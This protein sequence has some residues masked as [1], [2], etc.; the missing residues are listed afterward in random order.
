MKKLIEIKKRGSD[1]SGFT[2]LEYC[3]GAAVVV[4][5][6]WVALNALGDNLSEFLGAIGDWAT[7][8]TE[9]V[10]NAE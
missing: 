2:L 3:T 7:T 9:E 10:N 4:G 1:E 6:V 5:V 8:R